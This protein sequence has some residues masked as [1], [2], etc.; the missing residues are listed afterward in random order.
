MNAFIRWGIS[1]GDSRQSG[2][3]TENRNKGFDIRWDGKQVGK[4]PI[5]CCWI[6]A[7][8]GCEAELIPLLGDT[9]RFGQ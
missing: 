3:V 9:N 5:V 8:T 2:K 6:L 7:D 1:T 4:G